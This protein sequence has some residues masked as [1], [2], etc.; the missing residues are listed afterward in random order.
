MGKMLSSEVSENLLSAI[1][2]I[3]RKPIYFLN[4]LHYKIAFLT[5][6]IKSPTNLRKFPWKGN[7]S[8]DNDLLFPPVLSFT[9]SLVYRLISLGWYLFYVSLSLV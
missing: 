7:A 4:V 3:N 6:E 2:E 5:E 9:D 8:R 1:L